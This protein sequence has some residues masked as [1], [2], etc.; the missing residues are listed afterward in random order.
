[1]GMTKRVQ[2][3]FPDDLL[4]DIEKESQR[5]DVSMAQFVRDAVR[6]YLE[7]AKGRS[8]GQDALD[9]LA[10]FIECGTDLSENHDKYLY[11]DQK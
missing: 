5:R 10:G 3:F 7:E 4:T 1:M 6:K 2:F 11:G 8:S 9:E